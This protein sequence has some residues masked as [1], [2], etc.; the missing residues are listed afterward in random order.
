[1]PHITLTS[2]AG[3]A[4]GNAGEVH[5]HK[6]VT[7]VAD[8]SAFTQVSY[9]SGVNPTATKPSIAIYNGEGVSRAYLV[10]AATSNMMFTEDFAW[11]EQG[12]LPF[13][14]ELVNAAGSGD[15]IGVQ[16]SG[17]GIT[18]DVIVY[19]SKWDDVHGRRSSLS[20]ASPTISLAN[21]GLLIDNLPTSD[22]DPSVTH[23]EVWHSVDGASPALALRRQLGVTSITENVSTVLLGEVFGT[24]FERFPR[25]RYNAI[26]HD[27]QVLAGDDRHP[28][29]LYLSELLFPERYGGLFLRTRKGEP[30]VAIAEVRDVLL[31]FG[32]RSTYIVQGYTEDDLEMQVLEP[33]IGCVNH[34]GIANVHGLLV[35]PSHIGFYVSTGESFYFISK[36]FQQTW[37]DEYALHE[38]EYQSD[39][40]GVNDPERNVYKFWVKTLPTFVSRVLSTT[41]TGTRYGYWVLDYTPLLTEVGGSFEQPNLSFDMRS[42]Q[43]SAGAVL[44]IPGSS[45]GH[46]YWA[47]V[48]GSSGASYALR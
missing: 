44:T 38:V 2:K 8:D 3:A 32:P 48:T 6:P 10:G 37:R 13:T 19:L 46:L 4:F 42:R 11:L 24:S 43:D 34:F 5:Y 25:C 21:Q 45:R 33:Q 31:V 14:N 41:R 15:K 16:A 9:P 20:A 39:S 22:P 47:R 35:I 7:G 18:G 1:M 12:I 26:Y 30:I 17:T 23:I 27:R 28:D 36:D 29:R 40:W